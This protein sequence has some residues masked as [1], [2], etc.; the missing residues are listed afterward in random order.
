MEIGLACSW[1][2]E[3]GRP[4]R[5]A[6]EEAAAAAER[7]GLASLWAVGD[8]QQIGEGSHDGVLG[9]LVAARA[10]T[11]LRLGL[12]GD[13]VTARSVPVRAKQ[14]ATLDW[15]SGGR[16]A[17]GLDPA[18]PAAPLRSHLSEDD[19]SGD[20]VA[21]AV[22]HLA[23]MHALWTESRARVDT[24]HVTI[25]GA[26]ALP[27][28]AGGAGLPIHL[29]DVPDDRALGAYVDAAPRLAGWLAWKQDAGAVETASARFDR[30]LEQRGRDA[31]SVRR[32]WFVDAADWPGARE[33]ARD[34][35]LDE[36]VAVFPRVPRAEEVEG[37]GA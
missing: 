6:I 8:R 7:S 1:R 15:F 12:S 31:A 20:A 30:L 24:G 29:R 3:P 19:G 26:I 37:L 34:L 14:L 35:G 17:Y 33:T 10:T 5:A 25:R 2:A 13:A 23:A 27:K 16:L 4:L 36:V 11:R 32:T 21:K 22:D 18:E 9:L 28:P